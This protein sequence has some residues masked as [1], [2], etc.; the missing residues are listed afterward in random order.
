L[1]VSSN[2]RKKKKLKEEAINEILVADTN[3]E[4]G[5]EASDVEDYFEEE[6]VA[7]AVVM[8][9]RRSLSR[10]CHNKHWPAKSSTQLRCCLCFSRG[11]RKGTLYKC[12]RCDVGLCVVPCFIEYHTKICNISPSLC[13][14][15]TM[16]QDATDLY[17]SQNYVMNYLRH[18]S[19]NACDSQA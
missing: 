17:S 12:A 16:I 2:G 5:A 3:S 7:A 9:R 11:Q 1:W 13:H 19:Y 4:S 10:S 6:E 8:M 15:K 18:I 14:D